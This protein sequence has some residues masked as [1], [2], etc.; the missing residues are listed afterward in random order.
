[1]IRASPSSR[2]HSR[3]V[4]TR[5]LSWGRAKKCTE[6]VSLPR[7]LRATTRSVGGST[8]TFLAR[9]V[10]GRHKLWIRKACR[11]IVARGNGR[12]PEGDHRVARLIHISAVH[13]PSPWD[14]PSFPW[15]VACSCEVGPTPRLRFISYFDSAARGEPR[16]AP[17]QF[18]PLILNSRSDSCL[19]TG[20]PAPGANALSTSFFE[21]PSC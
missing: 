11:L 6:S 9:C 1:M 8:F 5:D 20:F 2:R 21:A 12:V 19:S 3:E 18:L 16:M 10:C 4:V 15:R 13:V 14:S 17:C 7:M